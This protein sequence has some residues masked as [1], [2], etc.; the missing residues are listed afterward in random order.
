MQR[1]APELLEVRAGVLLL[2]VGADEVVAC[3]V[4]LAREQRD[5]FQSALAVIKRSDQWLNDADGTVIGAGVAPGF[6]FVCRVD[7]PL[8]E[9]G[10]FVLIKAVMHTQGNLAVLERVGEVRDRRA[11][12]RRGCRR[13]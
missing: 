13:G 4:R 12:R 1:L 11:R 5:E 10:G 2:P 9:F 3:R 7:V 6:E 8:A